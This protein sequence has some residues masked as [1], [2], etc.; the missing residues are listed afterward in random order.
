MFVWCAT[1]AQVSAREITDVPID[2]RSARRER[3]RLTVID[4]VFDL[5]EEGQIPPDVNELAERSSVSVASIF[6]YFD[7]LEDIQLQAMERFKDRFLPLF[8]IDESASRSTDAR[9]AMY[10]DSRLAMLAQVGSVVA[11]ARLR[12]MENPQFNQAY[13]TIRTL[14]ADQVRELFAPELATLTPSAQASLVA[15]VDSLASPQAW[16]VMRR[17]HNQTARQI[18]T[19]WIATLQ[20]VLDAGSRTTSAEIAKD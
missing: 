7:G 1:L 14:L 11:L 15:V 10:V 6:R 4:A 9:I 16:D 13:D 19:A 3:G 2:G 17:S 12:A 20:A 18:R 5:I 8:R